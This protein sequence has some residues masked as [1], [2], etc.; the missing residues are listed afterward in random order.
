MGC[1]PKR[2]A[3]A[4][5]LIL[6]FVRSEMCMLFMG[7]IVTHTVKIHSLRCHIA[8]AD[9][10]P[11]HFVPVIRRTPRFHIPVIIFSCPPFMLFLSEWMMHQRRPGTLRDAMCQ[12]QTCSGNLA[13][14]IFTSHTQ[15]VTSSQTDMCSSAAA[16]SCTV[17]RV[18]YVICKNTACR[19]SFFFDN[20]CLVCA[21]MFFVCRCEFAL[22]V[23]FFLRKKVGIVKIALQIGSYFGFLYSFQFQIMTHLKARS[24]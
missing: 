24:K 9:V 12:R 1:W 17:C 7:Q 20:I 11:P 3:T 6:P 10:K 18:I 8:S 5:L 4:L 14:Y 16:A 19:F 21:C 2:L 13:I 15:G 22:C 23:S